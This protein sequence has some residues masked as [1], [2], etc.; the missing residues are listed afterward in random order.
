M[1]QFEFDQQFESDD[2]SQFRLMGA[3]SNIDNAQDI[4]L[5]YVPYSKYLY[6]KKY[7]QDGQS[8]SDDIMRTCNHTIG[9]KGCALTSFAMNISLEGNSRR[10]NPGT[11][12]NKMEDNACPFNWI[13]GARKYGLRCYIERRSY[14]DQEARDTIEGLIKSGETVIVGMNHLTNES[15]FVIARG[16]SN[17][18]GVDNIYIYDPSS[19]RNYSDLDSYLSRGYDVY[20][21]IYYK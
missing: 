7:F 17:N 4:S 19:S 16:Y 6:P 3:E 13:V 9:M 20:E 10:D 21:L 8:W 15:H 5:R 11:V 14:S 12:N 1:S 18:G 2:F